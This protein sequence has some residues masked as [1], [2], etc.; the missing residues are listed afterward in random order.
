LDLDHHVSTV[1][2]VRLEL[3]TGIWA[4]R[5]AERGRNYRNSRHDL[6]ITPRIPRFHDEKIVLLVEWLADLFVLF[7]VPGFG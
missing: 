5:S 6:K 7:P 3:S 2:H 4:F 1:S